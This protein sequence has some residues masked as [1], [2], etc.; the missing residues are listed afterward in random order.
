MQATPW[1]PEGVETILDGE[2]RLVDPQAAQGIDLRGLYK[3]L[4]HAR[5]LD[6]RLSRMGLPMWVPAAGEEAL[7]VLIGQLSRSEDWVY[8]GPRDAAIALARGVPIEAIALC[9][10]GDPSSETKGR[11][12][13]GPV[14]SVRHNIAVPGEALGMNLAI[15][16]GRAHGQSL[17]DAS[18]I[19]VAIVGEGVTTTGPFH[20]SMAIAV[21]NELPLVVVC[22]SQPWP[23]GAPAEAGHLG[24]HLT[25]RMHSAGCFSRRCDGADVVSCHRALSTALAHAREGDGP[26]FIEAFVTPLTPEVPLR[27]DPVERL[28]RHLEQ[29][30]EWTQTFQ[31]VIEAEFRGHFDKAI[32][33]AEGRGEGAA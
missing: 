30:G 13:P 31:D 24:D 14:A 9:A 4:V 17:D 28:R 16:A 3:A 33:T 25:A 15:A 18:G 5:Q 20:E 11:A 21:A 19:T 27:R 22:K 1:D 2:G 8:P 6:L 10:L 12:L 23:S 7:T 26:A 32:S 29:R